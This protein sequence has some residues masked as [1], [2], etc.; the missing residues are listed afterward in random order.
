MVVMERMSGNRL[1]PAE[2]HLMITAAQQPYTP[3]EEPPI[4]FLD[5]A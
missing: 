5:R 4:Y 1:R 3:T 2:E